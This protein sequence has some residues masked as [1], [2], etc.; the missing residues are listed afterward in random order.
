[1]KQSYIKATIYKQLTET[2]YQI[3]SNLKTTALAMDH[4][5]LKTRL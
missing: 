4:K 2:I 3:L 5:S 1:M